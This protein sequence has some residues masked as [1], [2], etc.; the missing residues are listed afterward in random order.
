LEARELPALS[1]GMN[2]ERVTDYSADW[3]FTDAFRESRPWLR[4]TNGSADFSIAV[5]QYG[6]PVQLTTGQSVTTFMFFNNGGHYPAGAYTAWWQGDGNVHWGGDVTSA[7]VQPGLVTGIDGKQYHAALLTVT[8]GSQGIQMVVTASSATD[9]APIHDV[10]VWMPDYNGQS[11]VGQIW[12]PG[13]NFSPFHPLFLQ[14]LAPFHTL[15]FL[16]D[17]ALIDS[18]VTDWSQVRPWNYET[19]QT[20][21]STSGYTLHNGIAPEYIVEL[22]N[23]LNADAWINIP[24]MADDAY[25]TNLANLVHNTLNPNLHIYLEWS[26]EVWNHAPGY[27]ASRWID[28]Q[29][30]LPQYAGWTFPQ[31]VAAQETHD[32]SL[33]SGVFA[34]HP[35]QLIRVVAGGPAGIYN[36]Q[37]LSWMHQDGDQF[38]AWSVNAYFGPS[39]ATVAGYT[40]S[41]VVSQVLADMSASIPATISNLQSN[42][43]LAAQYSTLLGRHIHF[44]AYEGGP[45]LMDTGNPAALPVVSAASVDP[46]VYSIFLNFLNQANLTGL[47]LMNNYEFTARNLPNPLGIFG[48]L[49]YMD[50]PVADAGKYHALLDFMGVTLGNSTPPPAPTPAPVPSPAPARPAAAPIFAVGADAGGAPE[51]RVYDARTGALKLDFYAYNPAFT[52]GVRVAVGDVNGDG[53][54]DI[55]TGTGPG[56]A[57]EVRVFDGN[58][59]AMLYDFF[60]Y[61]PAFTG[62]IFV[63]AGDING[64]G[65]A[66]IITGPDVGGGPEV[67]V[68]GGGAMGGRLLRDFFA[69]TPSFTGGVRVAAGD[70]TGAGRADIITGT[71]PGSA[72]EVRVF[73]GLDGSLMRD[74]FAYTPSFTGGLFV[75]AG[76]VNGDRMADIITGTGPGSAPEV[77]VFD[78]PTAAA[79]L[80][81]F[82]YTPSFSGGVRVAAVDV[83]AN[84]RAD[85]LTGPGPSGGPEA[86]V[87]DTLALNTVDDFFACNPAFLGGVF[88]GG[89]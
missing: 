12:S 5:D 18:N 13:A 32:Y 37:L 58:T 70:I 62:G 83:N 77:K 71:G 39:P 27:L 14:R 46:G 86:R 65:A 35:G 25:V 82:A 34:D 22:C 84:G 7:A 52:G 89:Q 1:I 81:F 60:A 55:I 6:N 4:Q 44:V 56:S 75:A 68:F 28:Q 10:H 79:L 11:F 43:A 63:A 48:A 21:D 33:W 31:F 67:R 72:P 8:P 64:D 38:D 66:D 45:A 87:F 20:P 24:H 76:D 17:S 41:T 26:N 19:Q 57:P 30:L 78:G 53:T 15:R 74:F 80:D 85:I 49:N 3:K 29:L 73:S 59:G 51:V 2:I 50:E 36:S 69:Y 61:S 16:Q 23:E 40:A 47:E 54:P 9:V 88:V 42:A